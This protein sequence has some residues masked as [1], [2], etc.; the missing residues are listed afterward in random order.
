MN[1]KLLDAVVILI[2]VI[3][4]FTVVLPLLQDLIRWMFKKGPSSA[5]GDLKD[6]EDEVEQALEAKR[7]AEEVIARAKERADATVEKA[8]EIKKKI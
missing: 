3:M 2:I 1:V 7:I 6:T 5:V 4:F 8:N